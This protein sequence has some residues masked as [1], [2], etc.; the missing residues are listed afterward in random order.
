MRTIASVAA[1]IAVSL[2]SL[3][4]SHAA[5]PSKS[6]PATIVIVFKDGHRQTFR[7]SDIARIDFGGSSESAVASSADADLPA[8]GQ[9]V[10]KWIVGVGGGNDDT[11]V[12]TL[13]EDGS[14]KR[15]LG[16]DVHGRWEYVNGEAQISWDDGAQDAI[17][18]AGSR[19][20]KYAY[21]S[22]KSF[23]DTPDNVTFARNT[24]PKPI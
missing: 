24:T 3:P 12:I 18:K 15:S 14:A 16:V 2:C 6:A 22:G 8:R 5:P 20:E 13:K 10:G 9:F 1:L 21:S 4:A 17:R 11:F 7:A 23:S 19:F